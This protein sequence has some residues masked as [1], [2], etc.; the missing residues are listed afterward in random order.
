[1][2]RTACKW[3]R[4]HL[5]SSSRSFLA[6]NAFKLLQ[7]S[8][9]E[10][11]RTPATHTTR[12]CFAMSCRR[13]PAIQLSS[14]ALA[15]HPSSSRM[16]ARLGFAAAFMFQVL[17]LALTTNPRNTASFSPCPTSVSSPRLRPKT[18]FNPLITSNFPVAIATLSCQLLLNASLH[19]LGHHEV[20]HCAWSRAFVMSD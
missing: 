7:K 18:S 4:S 3:V 11:S 1:M 12:A 8:R 15:M 19:L 13:C 17:Q 5:L 16:H 2:A 20:T 6:A 10:L 9:L 14:W